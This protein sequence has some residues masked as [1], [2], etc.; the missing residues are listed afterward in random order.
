MR[1]IEMEVRQWGKTSCAV[2]GALAVVVGCVVPVVGETAT[3]VAARDNTLY[4]SGPGDV[5]NGAGDHL[6]VGRVGGGGG[7]ARRRALL[8]FDLQ[9]AIPTGATVDSAVLRLNLSRTVSG[10][11]SVSLH[12]V[13][14]D[15]GAAG[16]DA[17]G[18][19]GM[20]AAAETGDATWVHR[21]FASANWQNVG[22][23]FRD[24]ASATA[25]V[26][27]PGPYQ[28][29]STADLVADVQAWTDDPA[30]N[31]GWILVGNEASTSTAKRFDSRDNDNADVRPRLIVEFTPIT[32][33][34]GNGT[35]DPEDIANGTSED[36][37]EDGVPDECQVDTDNDGQIDACDD[38]PQ[39]PNKTA[40]GECG[41]GNP[42]IDTDGD[43]VLDC[44]DRCPGADDLLDTDGDETPDCRD[45]CPEDPDK[46]DPG[47]LGCGIAEDDSD[48]DGVPDGTDRCP[49]ADDNEDRDGDGTPDCLDDCPDDP[50]KTAPGACGCGTNEDDADGD[51]TP[52]CLDDCPDDPTKTAAGDCGCGTPN[53][54]ADNDGVPDCIDNCPDTANA[55]Q[56]DSDNDG[57]GDACTPATVDD[58]MPPTNDSD[59]PNDPT[60]P[61]PT[62]PLPDC[63]PLC[64][65]GM[66]PMVPLTFAGIGLLKRRHRPRNRRLRSSNGSNTETTPSNQS[67]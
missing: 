36:C 33:C 59:D 24:A 53:D 27:G 51:G 67:R 42:D 20:G 18:G 43:S 23:D 34:N 30:S 45:G 1:D 9:A 39:D 25:V 8:Y 35:D 5:S 4:E 12:R 22:G 58:D 32:D 61:I 17:G 3:L 29:Q 11:Q 38:C 49:G 26:A 50:D 10:N 28:W 15:W 65:M 55:M 21:F 19:E 46:T 47:L 14:A 16:S 66:M 60:Q 52:D 7:G 6:F 31:F 41:C 37:N 54:D 57:V 63:G 62:D 64:G 13:D 40:A 56:V 2:I 48:A 44:R